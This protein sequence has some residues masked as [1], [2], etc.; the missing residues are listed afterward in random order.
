VETALKT[1]GIDSN[2][3]LNSNTWN[4]SNTWNMAVTID[5]YDRLEWLGDKLLDFGVSLILFD[6]MP[7]SDCGELTRIRSLITR[8]DD[9]HMT[10]PFV[11]ICKK[12]GLDKQIID[13]AT[14]L[15]VITNHILSDI[16]EAFIGAMFIETSANVTLSFLTNIINDN[17]NYNEIIESKQNY[18]DKLMRYYHKIFTVNFKKNTPIYHFDGKNKCYISDP[19]SKKVCYGIGASQYLAE[20]S[21]AKNALKKYDILDDNKYELV[22]ASLTEKL[23]IQKLEKRMAIISADTLNMTDDLSDNIIS[24]ANM[25][26]ID[27]NQ[28][29]GQIIFDNTMIK[30][31][32]RN[33]D[34]FKTA[35][36]HIENNKL[37][38][39][40]NKLIEASITIIL[41]AYFPNLAEGKLSVIRSIL[42]RNSDTLFGRAGLSN[43]A[44]Y[45]NFPHYIQLTSHAIKLDGRNND[46]ILTNVLE[47]FFAALFL[48]SDKNFSFVV[49]VLQSI[50]WKFVDLTDL[51]INHDEYTQYKLKLNQIYQ[52][53]NNSVY[54]NTTEIT[55]DEFALVAVDPSANPEGLPSVD[56]SGLPSV[57]TKDTINS[58][59]YNELINEKSVVK[60]HIFKCTIIDKK[61]KKIIGTGYGKKIKIAEQMAAKNYFTIAAELNDLK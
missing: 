22:M 23:R 26:M 14:V 31:R 1:Y 7:N 45:L 27:I 38:W 20:V 46:K 41:Y 25:P 24:S 5:K 18:K 36:T 9:I 47:A 30:Y 17:V 2:G 44:R 19:T 43:M 13:T 21:A 51:F 8:N 33:I 58:L 59:L 60:S 10:S 34:I 54:Y 6:K 48:D 49:Y 55:L 52:R 11:T 57:D 35:F 37:K 15:P 32:I 3:P 40:G 16:F 12:I 39:M 29:I 42:I 53:N 28:F 50:I 61:M 4:S 56:P